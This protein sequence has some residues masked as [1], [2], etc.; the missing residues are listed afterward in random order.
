MRTRIRGAVL[1]LVA[2]PLALGACGDDGENS[3]PGAWQ[4]RVGASAAAAVVEIH[5][6]GIE[7][8]EAGGTTR[9]IH[10]QIG[11]PDSEGTSI[12]RLVLIAEGSETLRFQVRVRDVA[13]GTPNAVVIS[14]SDAANRPI[15]SPGSVGVTLSR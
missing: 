10:G 9:L 12:H 7:A 1:A 13:A 2:L 6:Q 11:Q 8:V 5:G 3:G 15:A 14:A 4:G